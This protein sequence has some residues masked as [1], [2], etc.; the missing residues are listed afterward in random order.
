VVL[1]LDSGMG[2]RRRRR[3]D[4][5]SAGEHGAPGGPGQD[6]MLQYQGQTFSNITGLGDNSTSCAVVFSPGMCMERLV[7]AVHDFG[8]V[9]DNATAGGSKVS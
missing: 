4:R 2:R 5:G 9:N 1:F 8:Y 3:G 6:G 7:E